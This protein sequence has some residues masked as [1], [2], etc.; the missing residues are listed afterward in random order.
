MPKRLIEINKFT[1]GIVSTPS[2]TDTDEQSAKYSLNIDP[3]TSDGR[4]QSIDSDKY[5]TSDGFASTGTKL[6]VQY[7]REMITVPDK[8][9]KTS[10]NLVIGRNSSLGNDFIDTISI[11]KDLYGKNIALQDLNDSSLSSITSEYDFQSNDDKVFIGLGGSPSSSSKVVMTPSGTTI[12]G[13]D[14]GGIDLFDAELFPPNATSFSSMFSEFTTFPIHG[15]TVGTKNLAQDDSDT[16]LSVIYPDYDKAVTINSGVTLYK[17]LNQDAAVPNSGIL[18]G[19]KVG[20]I[21]K[22]ADDTDTLDDALLAW[23]RYDYDMYASAIAAHDLFMFCGYLNEGSYV[24][25]PVLRF[26]G[27]AATQT[28]AFTYAIKD[29]SS[30]LYKISL[31][32][33]V[34]A[35]AFPT[36]SNTD[37]V[38]D[39]LG[40]DYTIKNVGSRITSID[41]SSLSNWQGGYISAFSACSSPPL[42]NSIGLASEGRDPHETNGEIYYN[43]GHLKIL[44]RHGIFYIGNKNQTS[45]MYRLNAIDFHSLTDLGVKIEGIRLDF[46]RIPDQLHAEGGK[47]I[48]RRTIEDQLLNPPEDPARHTWSNIPQNAEIIGI[49][50]TFDCGQITKITP[51]TG[52]NTYSNVFGYK[53]TGGSGGQHRLTSGDKV[54]FAGMTI[55]AD[56]HSV[57][58]SSALEDFN[59]SAPYEV[60]VVEEGQA[61]WINS[62]SASK[63][64]EAH[65]GPNYRAAMWWNAKV[66]VLYGKKS[67]TASFDKW[68]LFLYN[69]NTLEMDNN[70][71]IYMADRTPPFQQA[72][73]YETTTKDSDEI[74]KIWYPG[75]FAFIKKDPTPGFSNAGTDDG[76][77]EGQGLQIGD[78]A[79]P[80]SFVGDESGD[81]DSGM[82]CEIAFYD[83]AG[84]WS[85]AGTKNVFPEDATNFDNPVDWVG[86]LDGPIATIGTEDFPYGHI[87]GA[88][89]IGNNIGWSTEEN[90]HRQVKPLNNSLHPHVPYSTLYNSNL[91]YCGFNKFDSSS[92]GGANH[93]AVNYADYLYNGDGYSEPDD[94]L[95]NHNR[96]KHAVTFIGKVKGTFVAHPGIIQRTGILSTMFSHD[97]MDRAFEV[98]K[99]YPSKLKKYNDDYTLFTI[100]DFSGHS[101]SVIQDNGDLSMSLSNSNNDEKTPLGGVV[102]W[103]PNFG[104]PEIE[105][106]KFRQTTRIINGIEVGSLSSVNGGYGHSNPSDNDKG[107]DG[108]APPCLFNP[109][110]G[111]YVYI[112]RSWQNMSEI[113]A[114]PLNPI[115]YANYTSNVTTCW[116]FNSTLDSVGRFNNFSSTCISDNVATHSRAIIKQNINDSNRYINMEAPA[117]ESDGNSIST[118]FYHVPNNTYVAGSGEFNLTFRS[119]PS[120]AQSICTMHKLSISN[121]HAIN[122]IFPVIL[123]T[124]IATDQTAGGDFVPAYICGLTNEGTNDSGIAIIRTNFDYIW[125]KYANNLDSSVDGSF[126]QAIL[127]TNHSEPSSESLPYRYALNRR[128]TH[129]AEIIDITDANTAYASTTDSLDGMQIKQINIDTYNDNVIGNK[130]VAL[131]QKPLKGFTATSVIADADFDVWVQT[132][133]EDGSSLFLGYEDN[134]YTRNVGSPLDEDLNGTFFSAN[135]GKIFDSVN[136]STILTTLT[137][138]L[139]FANSAQGTS[140]NIVEGDYYYKLAY[141]YDDIYH[142]PLT[143]TSIKHTVSPTVA[144]EVFDYIS[145][146]VQLPSSI[147]TSIPKRV[148]GIA[149]YRKFEGGEDDAYSLVNIVK[150]SDNWIYNSANDIYTKTIYDKDTLMGTY[151]ANNGIDETLQNTSLNYGLS[152]V[153]Q[154]YLFV[155]KAFHPNLS[156]VKNYIF[157]SQPDNF[158]TFNWIEDFV[159]MPEVPI[160]MVSFNS[161]LYVWG[162]NALYKLDPF[163]MLIEDTYEGVSIINKDSF[164]KTEYGLCFM[165]KNNVYIH[166]GNKPVAIADAILYSSNDSVVY[167]T[168]GTDGYIKLQQ[169]YRELVEQTITNGHKPHIT[170]SG[171]H[172]SFLVHLSNASTDGKTF[173]FNLNKRRWDL[174]DSPKPYAITSSKDSD[175]IIADTDNIYNYIDLKSEEFTDYNRRTWDWFSKDINFGTDT[176]DKVFRSIKFLGTP[177]IYETGN[178]IGVYDSSNSK[179]ASVQAYVDNDLVDLTVKNKF[180]ETINLG[181]TYLFS[182][183]FDAN[184]TVST[185]HIKTQIQP[186][187]SNGAGTQ[188][189]EGNQSFIRAGHLIKIQNEIMLVKSVTNYTSFT[190]LFVERAVM[191]TTGEVHIGGVTQTIDIVS[192]ILKFPAGTKGKN[193]S[194]RLT[195]QKGYI[196]SIG[197]VYKPKS[198]K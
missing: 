18:A 114:R 134:A 84:R 167:N 177:S 151:F 108:Y 121:E 103:R 105:N 141:E 130:L 179:T 154:G 14:K 34:D 93:E 31:T 131:S 100:D 170:Y 46:S 22:C 51:E 107:W 189:N 89:M 195:G 74:G 158:F 176:Q 61:F 4:L 38:K 113:N 174:W 188:V 63:I 12:N 136:D 86:G 194:I 172:N 95:K 71:N 70:R 25:V 75:Q 42:Y 135:S 155:T 13:Q 115:F 21:F 149:V 111:Y 109:G 54:R 145:V 64:P 171:K 50:E 160:A 23:K 102:T 161:R 139:D 153:N 11:V 7:V 117:H 122:N 169:G 180:Y 125:D 1:G 27:N 173:A 119:M 157:R 35:T 196:D 137:G 123:N 129:L 88:L 9:N 44:Y 66:W 65:I 190:E 128:G 99:N 24:D 127:F 30:S 52:S 73:Y 142:S 182:N 193:L 36:S 116:G 97:R 164:V 187:T 85:S 76:E 78:V 6:T 147:V 124:N 87:N 26:I 69:A 56:S 148:T 152:A 101:G 110:S 112:N 96:P 19:L 81:Q 126:D 185:L 28:A 98:N 91:V 162:Q 47:G 94:R 175:I 159:I 192:P 8:N 49:C 60:S 2:A 62:G 166:D 33:T 140:G 67:N 77:Y 118:R 181:G 138:G 120:H 72:R 191:G 143:S 79:L 146:T 15:N 55:S 133:S 198:I 83:K 17:T 197:V 156:D 68:D 29:E 53:I 58:T 3:Q 132:N 168:T 20:Q 82:F 104:G 5:L 43:N 37:I 40:A 57:V 144:G 92:I 10:L 186:N 150:I 48:V 39:S 90:E 32:T 165:D 183:L 45:A 178:T 59:V 41:L 16:P 106:P 184:P 80:G 163:S